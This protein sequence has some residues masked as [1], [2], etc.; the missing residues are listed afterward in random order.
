MTRHFTFAQRTNWP[1]EKNQL[2]VTLEK[3]QNK[4]VPIIDLTE[5]NPT[6]CD[7]D[8]NNEEILNPFNEKTNLIYEPS[9]QGKSSTRDVIAQYYKTKNQEVPGNRIF[10]TS[11]TS[12]AYSYLFRLL[13]DVKAQVLFP[14]PSYPLFQFLG[15]LNDIQLNYYSLTYDGQWQIDWPDFKNTIGQKTKAIVL[16]NPNNPT[17]NFLK[18]DDISKLNEICQQ[19]NIVLIC[20]EVFWDFA[21]DQTKEYESLVN[22]EQV[23]TFTLGGLSKTLGLPQMKLSWII[24][25]GPEKLVHDS[26]KRLE[27]ISDTYL[28][29]NTPTQNA[30]ARWISKK[31]EIQKEILTRIK[32]NLTFLHSQVHASSHCQFY[33]VEGG[34]Y[35]VIKIPSMLSEEEW[36]LKFLEDDHVYVHPGYYFDFEQEAFI[37]ICLL[38]PPQMLQQG[39]ERIINRIR[40]YQA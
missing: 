37:I 27:I 31:D 33:N 34:W 36:V 13:V 20:D 2:T 18:K 12:E 9:P 8:Y 25:N 10:L 28:S 1:L 22:N 38:P 39:I 16:V 15:D 14:R 29:V 26:I 40:S 3:L 6:R 23:L 19:K 17:G 4:R 35:V 5:S 11:S 7:F 32:Q 24:I 21:F 30:L